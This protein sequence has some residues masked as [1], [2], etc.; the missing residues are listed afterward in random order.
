M[1]FGLIRILGGATGSVAN[2]TVARLVV[3]GGRAYRGMDSNLGE[4]REGN[5]TQVED[6]SITFRS[7][8]G[9]SGSCDQRFSRYRRLH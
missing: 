5:V 2:I 4:G 8:S 7:G 3:M 6:F 1:F 9:G